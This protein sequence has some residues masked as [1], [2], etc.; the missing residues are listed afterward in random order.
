VSTPAAK[1]LPV[2]VEVGGRRYEGRYK[3]AS[4]VLT[5]WYGPCAKSVALRYPEPEFQAKLLLTQMAV[6]AAQPDPRD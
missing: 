2:R 4:G 5:V 1:P 6:E 3:A